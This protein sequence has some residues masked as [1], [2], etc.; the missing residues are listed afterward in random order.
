MEIL[1]MFVNPPEDLFI[2]LR[3]PEFSSMSPSSTS[4][5]VRAR[6][7]WA[8]CTKSEPKRSEVALS[9][10]SKT[11]YHLSWYCLVLVD[12]RHMHNSEAFRSSSDQ[13]FQCVLVVDNRL[14]QLLANVAW[15]VREGHTFPSSMRTLTTAK[16]LWKGVPVVDL[17][18]F[19]RSD[20]M[21]CQ[22]I[23]RLSFIDEFWLRLCRL[24]STGGINIFRC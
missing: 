8:S 5:W 15:R 19:W 24:R 14:W 6:Y 12:Q 10:P 23:L 4:C 1:H 17:S 18:A 3:S 20:S 21:P 16:G 11:L 2:L 13:F 7:Q 9:A 22:A